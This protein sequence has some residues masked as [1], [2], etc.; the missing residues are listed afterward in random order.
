MY[1]L[2]EVTGF[3]MPGEAVEVRV[4]TVKNFL[5]LLFTEFG[6]PDVRVFTASRST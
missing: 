2:V 1:V 6:Y 3:D 4:N 5:S